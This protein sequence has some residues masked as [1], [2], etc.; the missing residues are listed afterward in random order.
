MQ[1]FITTFP[2]SFLGTWNLF[3]EPQGIKKKNKT[4][5]NEKEKNKL[6]MK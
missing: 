6:D 5:N 1:I 4:D 2:I 3:R